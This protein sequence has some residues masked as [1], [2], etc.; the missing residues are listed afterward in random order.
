MIIVCDE[1]FGSFSI[2]IETFILHDVIVWIENT[3]NIY[4]GRVKHNDSSAVKIGRFQENLK[5]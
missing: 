1:E 5:I 2:V 3:Q 4:Y